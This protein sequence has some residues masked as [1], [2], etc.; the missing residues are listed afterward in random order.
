MGAN[1]FL[2]SL[3]AEVANTFF[4][5]PESHGFVVA[6]GAALIASGLITRPTEDLDLFASAP[7]SSVT[8]AARALEMAMDSCGYQVRIVRESQTFCRMVIDAPGE[9]VLVDLAIDS[10][11]IAEIGTT[12]LGPTLEAHELAVRKVLALFGRAEARD[13]A[14]VFVLAQRFGREALLDTAAVVDPGFDRVVIAQ[15]MRTI[16]RFADDEIPLS[17]D[18][19]S[20]VREYFAEWSEDLLVARETEA[21]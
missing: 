3:Q 17:A 5:L 18:A 21:D 19:V 12:V 13:F 2:T 14:D 8:A 6:G 11:P 4:E 10:P 9:Q 15:M 20:G 1:G 16:D 7:V